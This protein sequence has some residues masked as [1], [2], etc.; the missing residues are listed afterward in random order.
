M[1]S[2][3]GIFE[4]VA[5]TD[6]VPVADLSELYCRAADGDSNAVRTR[7]AEGSVMVEVA[8]TDESFPI[9][10]ADCLTMVGD[11]DGA[12]EWLGRAVDWGFCNYRYLEEHNPFLRPLRGNPRFVQL[13]DRARQKQETFDA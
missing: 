5:A 10:I 1:G 11:H 4:E 13:I 12:L 9:F 6:A 8:K 2:E 3:E 7:V